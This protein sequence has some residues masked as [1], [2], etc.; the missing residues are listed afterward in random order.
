MARLVCCPPHVGRSNGSGRS[1]PQRW[2]SRIPAGSPSTLS[3]AT[4]ITTCQSNHRSPSPASSRCKA[5]PHIRSVRS[6]LALTYLNNLLD[7][8]EEARRMGVYGHTS[9]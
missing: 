6:D 7:S 9:R 3:L 8:L 5:D 1:D 4:S 2:S